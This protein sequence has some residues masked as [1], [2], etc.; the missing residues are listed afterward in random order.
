MKIKIQRLHPDAIL[1]RYAHP[2]DSG[3]DLF[4]IESM[5]I[6]PGNVYHAK[7]G[8]A[9]EI[10][11]GYEGQIRPKSGRAVRE[12]LSVIFGTVDQA[13]RGEIGVML[14]AYESPVIIEKYQK[15]AQLVIVPV[16][17]VEIVEADS[18]SETVRGQGGFGSTGIKL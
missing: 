13:Y 9:V 7:T 2:G 12:S 18:L 17:Q 11:I 6:F 3:M 14:V 1:P 8:I 10:P 5:V 4:A 16:V 15:I